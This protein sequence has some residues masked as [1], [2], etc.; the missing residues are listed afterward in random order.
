[1]SGTFG[2]WVLGQLLQAVQAEAVV[3]HRYIF[4][5]QQEALSWSWLTLRPGIFVFWIQLPEEVHSARP[6]LTVAGCSGSLSAFEQPWALVLRQSQQGVVSGAQLDKIE[7]GLFES[8]VWRNSAASD[9][10]LE[11]AIESG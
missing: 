8:L 5:Q 7:P 4:C 1:M 6:S 3:C 9:E 11:A 10:V 2:H